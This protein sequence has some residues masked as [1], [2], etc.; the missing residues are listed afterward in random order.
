MTGQQL[1]ERQ[2]PLKTTYRESPATAQ[3][4]LRASGDVDVSQIVCRVP[5]EG[6]SA[7]DFGLHEMAAGDA[8][9][10]CAADLL[11]QSLAACA[12][13]TFG[14]VATALNLEVR[15]AQFQ[16]EG[17]LDFRGTLGVNRDVPVG[18]TAIRI[19][20]LIDS[21]AEDAQLIKVLELVER[22][23]VVA[24]SLRTPLTLTFERVT[25]SLTN[26]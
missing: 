25:K 20:L 19:R 7:V 11:L 21:P 10:N 6:G 22:Y 14:A 5:L 1:R 8:G 16:I 13:V 9:T 15:S 4:V 26:P 17:D 23:C 3:A 2:A 24:Q 12:G 18:F